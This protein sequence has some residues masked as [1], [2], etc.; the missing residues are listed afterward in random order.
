ME[1]NKRNQSIAFLGCIL[2]VGTIQLGNMGLN[3]IMYPILTNLGGLQYY[4]LQTVLASLGTAVMTPIGGRLGDLFGRR[5]IVLIGSI[6]FMISLA[7]MAFLDQLVFFIAGRLIFGIGMGLFISIPFAICA[8]IFPGDIYPKKVAMLSASLSACIVLGSTIAGILY[9]RGL[10]KVAILYPGVLCILGALMIY[11]QLPASKSREKPLIDYTGICLLAVFMSA[12]SLSFSFGGN[13]GFGHPTILAGFAVTVVSLIL[14]YRVETKKE[15]PVIPFYL[16]RNI[17][18]T[19]ICIV[20][21][22]VSTYQMMMGVYVPVTGQKI[23]NLSSTVTGMFTL[24]RSVL[25][26]IL[27]AIIAV[28]VNNRG[29]RLRISQIISCVT[30]VIAFAGLSMTGPS[31]PMLVPFLLLAITGIGEGYRAVASNPL[32][33]KQLESKD[34]GIGIALNTTIGTVISTVVSAGIGA[35]Y[36]RISVTSLGGALRMVYIL[37]TALA[38]F[39]VVVAVVTLKDL[40]QEKT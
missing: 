8:E 27:P 37:T 24:P 28:W 40:R 39:C 36:T 16:F 21:G 22:M 23:M 29:D 33:V 6:I 3:N 7:M 32:L 9:E 35:V 30:V 10:L 25:C 11:T 14:L 31:T 15:Q 2:V 17:K 19:G 12:L 5:T 13:I 20:T 34:M 26:V 4:A 1:L 18:F 38:V